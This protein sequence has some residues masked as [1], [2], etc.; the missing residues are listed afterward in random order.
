MRKAASRLSLRLSDCP[1]H[2]ETVD[3]PRLA[4]R[5]FSGMTLMILRFWRATGV[6]ERPIAEED[7]AALRTCSS[8]LCPAAERTRIK[9]SVAVPRVLAFA[10]AVA[11]VRDVPAR[12]AISA[13]VSFP[14]C[15]IFAKAQVSTERIIELTEDRS[16]VV[17]HNAVSWELLV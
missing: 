7:A 13:W 4:T 1:G 11:R 12:L 17:E 2:I 14:F 8:A 9:R 5:H 10:T 15:M 3:F 6:T 16:E